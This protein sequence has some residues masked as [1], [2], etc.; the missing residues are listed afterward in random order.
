MR[1]VVPLLM[2]AAAYEAD[3]QSNER[4]RITVRVKQADLSFDELRRLVPAL[5]GIT[6]P[7]DVSVEHPRVAMDYR[8]AHD[9]A[10]RREAETE[11]L[12]R[13]MVHYRSLFEALVS[14]PATEERVDEREE[15]RR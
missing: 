11:D 8:A 12:R 14:A 1:A 15:T 3:A 4:P 5:E 7:P 2:L 9:I 10:R 13:A 6:L